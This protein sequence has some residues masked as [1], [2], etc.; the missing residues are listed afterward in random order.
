[1]SKSVPEISGAKDCGGNVFNISM[2]WRWNAVLASVSAD[3]CRFEIIFKSQFRGLE[4]IAELV[5]G[6]Y[7]QEVPDLPLYH[8]GMGD[9]SKIKTFQITQAKLEFQS[10]I[11]H[12]APRHKTK[13]LFMAE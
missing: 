5:A 9:D 2:H 4:F 1:L 7:V 3:R 6:E 13:L 11:L 10:I 12:L 8:E